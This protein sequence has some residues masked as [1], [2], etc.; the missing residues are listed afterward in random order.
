MQ[1]SD[2]LGS[3]NNL[4]DTSW[5]IRLGKFK[6]NALASGA[7]VLA[8]VCLSDSLDDS[9]TN[10]DAVGFDYGLKSTELFIRLK[11]IDGVHFQ[12]GGQSSAGFSSSTVPSTTT[13]YRWELS[14]NG[15]VY[16]MKAFAENDTTYST[17][18]E[19]ETVTKTGIT[20]LRYLKIINDSEQNNSAT[21]DM[22][23]F[24]DI[25]IWNGTT[26][27]STND[28]ALVSSLSDKANLKAYY[29]MNST[30]LTS[31]K[32]STDFDD[33]FSGTDDWIDRGTT[34]A[35]DTTNDRINYDVG[36]GSGTGNNATYY[37]L[38]VGNVSNTKWTLRWKTYIGSAYSSDSSASSSHM[39]VG[40][41]KGG[42]DMTTF[43]YNDLQ[44]S[45]MAAT[46]SGD[47]GGEIYY[48]HY[49]DNANSLDTSNRDVFSRSPDSDKGEWVWNTLK[50][51][52]PTKMN[53]TIRSTSHTGTVL[54]S[55]TTTIASGI[56]GL[57]YIAVQSRQQNANSHE[58]YIDDIEF[59]NDSAE[60]TGCK[61]DFSST[62]A[63]DGQTNLP[64]NTIFEQIDDT[65]TYY[66]KQSDNTWKIDGTLPTPDAW[67]DMSA[68][69]TTISNVT[70]KTGNGNTLVQ[71]TS[72]KR[73]S[74]ASS[75][76]NGL[77]ALQFDE[78]NEYLY[79][80][81]TMTLT[82]KQTIFYV[83]KIV[84]GTTN[85]GWNF[86]VWDGDGIH[87]SLIQFQNN[88][89][90][91]DADFGDL[92]ETSWSRWLQL[93][94]QFNG[95]SSFL[96]DNGVQTDNPDGVL[97]TENTRKFIL[98]GYT[99]SGGYGGAN[100]VGE[101]IIYNRMLNSTEI[102]KVETYLKDKWGTP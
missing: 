97:K 30:A 91:Y 3:G 14:R 89:R 43:A 35:V 102:E 86:Y 6:V 69:D 81:D 100:T 75:A 78:N 18:L 17:P 79:T 74:V 13:S 71:S 65:P 12:G 95:S 67:W 51:E 83:G 20:G 9:G 41:T 85:T 40:I 63:L 33:D 68:S 11:V 26:S 25:K 38:G 22:E 98:N 5:V 87:N 77:N 48:N 27:A 49:G 42:A 55:K 16:T 88:W 31:L 99:N 37:D 8:I 45:I 84:K 73:P 64:V 34:I 62:S 70:D 46:G 52:S 96:R 23:I 32:G 82:P 93:T 61:N 50:R 80:T 53:W 57:R 39:G 54:E 60:T 28:G 10:Q 58:G 101:V 1:D 7:N 36:N 21:A 56:A 76:Q 4:S 90:L 2:Y 19:T 47:G 29:S 92:S 66:W 44:D 15:N 94:V 24:G 59:Y 72:S